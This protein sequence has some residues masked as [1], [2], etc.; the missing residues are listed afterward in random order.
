MKEKNKNFDL[1]VIIPVFNSQKSVIGAIESCLKQ[2]YKNFHICIVD[3]CSTDNTYESIKKYKDNEKVT[4]LRNDKN[5][6][7]YYSRNRALKTFKDYKWKYFTTH[8]ADDNSTTERFKLVIKK[9]NE[10]NKNHCVTTPYG[11]IKNKQVSHIGRGDGIA[12]Y[13]REVFDTLGYYDNTRFAGDT[14]YLNRFIE[15]NRIYDLGKITQLDLIT[16]FASEN[17]DNLTSKYNRDKRNNYMNKKDLEY[18]KMKMINNFY[19]DFKD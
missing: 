5:Q 19:R 12:F 2:S 15:Y 11:R 14:E 4:I 7:C 8:D 13:T 6:G 17:E 18:Y 3:D 1:L 16:Y 10:N 9:F